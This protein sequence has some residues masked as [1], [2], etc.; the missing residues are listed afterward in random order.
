[1]TKDDMTEA[2]E[3]VEDEATVDRSDDPAGAE[4]SNALSEGKVGDKKGD[5]G[6][7]KGKTKEEKEEDEEE[8]TGAFPVIPRKKVKR[9]PRI[10]PMVRNKALASVLIFVLCLA[11]GFGYMWQSRNVDTTYSNLSE[12][13]LVRLLDETNSQISK[14]ETQK[15]NLNSQLSSIKSAANKQEEIIKIAKENEQINGILS[16]RLQ[17]Q[18]QGAVITITQKRTPISSTVLFSVL[19]ELRNAGAE[20]IELNHVRIITSSYIVDTANGVECD[21]QLISSPYVFRAIGSSS[22]LD[23]A[24]NIAGGVGSKLRVT[25]GATVKVEESDKV[26]ISATVQSRENK[27][28][29]A[30]GD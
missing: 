16:G 28:A 7:K 13:E 21:G 15:A 12:D 1:M 3:N 29:K 11:L 8:Q 22:A 5:K 10:S 14:L 2:R 25:Y 4:E 19:E 26:L 27:Y 30:V 17:A 6:T 18:G 9:I 20:V 24:I 23:N